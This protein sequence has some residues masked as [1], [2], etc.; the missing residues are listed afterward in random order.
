METNTKPLPESLRIMTDAEFARRMK[1]AAKKAKKAN[2]K[3]WRGW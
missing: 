2:T 1:L 3:K